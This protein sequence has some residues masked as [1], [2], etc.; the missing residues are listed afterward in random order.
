M[1]S[2]L[3]IM[4]KVIEIKDKEGK[5]DE[6]VMIYPT[7]NIT[8]KDLMK[9]GGKFYAILNTDTG[10]WITNESE[11]YDIIDKRLY[12]KL[13]EIGKEDGYGNIRDEKGRKIIVSTMDDSSTKNYLE[14]SNWFSKL[15]P[16][17]NLKP[18]DSNITFQG[19]DITPD[20]YVTKT[21]PYK[22]EKGSINAYEKL[23]NTLYSPDDRKKIEWAIGSVFNGDSK[24][25]EKF[26]VLYGDPGTGKSTVLDLIKDLFEGYYGI[27]VAAELA[28]KQSTFATSAFKDNPL[29]AIQDDGSL[30]KIDSPVINEI[31]SHKEV[32]INEKNK[33]QYPIRANAILFMATNELV[34]LH[35]TKLGITRRLLDVYPTGNKL[36]VREYRK[37]VSDLKYELGAIA[38]H[39]KSVYEE[40][41][42]EYY[43]DYEPREMIRKTNDLRNF[44][45]D[46]FDL[47]LD[48]KIVSRDL[49]YKWYKAYCEES[50]ITYILKRIDFGEQLREYYKNFYEIKWIDGKSQ[51]NIFEGFKKEKFEYASVKFEMKVEEE[52]PDWLKFKNTRSKFD[53]LYLDSPAQYA[54]EVGGIS[55]P[56]T[57][58]ALCTSTLKEIDTK[59]VHYVKPPENLICIDFDIKDEEGNKDGKKNLV[60]AGK[61]PETYGEYSKSGSGV[62]LYYIYNGDVSKLRSL[63]DKDIEIK[64]FRG[65]ASLR[66]KLTKCNDKEIAVISSGL[67]TKGEKVLDEYAV[68]N[69]KHLR[70]LIGKALRKEIEP[71]ATKTCMDYI[72][73]VTEDAYKSGLHFDVTDLRPD[74]Q[75]FANNSTH[76]ASY[77]LNLINKIHFA[78]DEA[79]DDKGRYDNDDIIIFDCEV[80]ENLFIVCWKVKGEGHEV[81]KMINPT[82]ADIEDLCHHKLVGYNNRA[83]DNH[84]LYARI[85]GYNN[86]QLY[87]L[88]QRLIGDQGRNAKFLEAYK[89][90]YSDVYDFLSAGNK[91]GL[92]KWEI[93]LGIHHQEMGIPWDKPVPKD[94]WELVADYCANDVI[95]T[96]KTWDANEADWLAREILADISGLTVNDTTNQCTTKLIVGNDKNPQDEFIYTDL[97]TIFPGYTF[98]KTGIDKKL[99]N[100]GTKIVAGKSLYLG[101]DPGEGGYVYAEPGIY[102]NV[103]LLDVASMHPHSA[104]RLKVFGE[105][106]TKVFEELV[107]ARVAIK[108]GDFEKAGKLLGG[109]LKPYLKDKKDAKK[110]ANALKTAINS[111]YGLTSATFNNKLRD[112]RNVDNI[113]A[114]Y[115]ALFMINLKHEV[116]KKGYTVV[117][118]KTDSIKIANMDDYIKDFCM[119]YANKYGFEFEHEATYE[120]ICLVNEAVY[121]AKDKSDGHWT[122]TGAQFQIPY[123]FKTL[124]SHEPVTFSDYCETKS[125]TTA[126]YLDFNENLKDVDEHNYEFVGKVGSFVP[127]V[128]GVGGGVLV[129]EKDGKYYAAT[130]T[131]KPNGK[132]VYRWLEAEQVKILGLEDKVDLSYFNNLANT[133]IETIDKFGD[134]NDFVSDTPSF[135]QIPDT[136]KDEIPFETIVSDD[137]M[138][139]PV[140]A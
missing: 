104:I 140:A 69:D 64:T 129:R 39:C 28:N 14:F 122:A 65:K 55:K 62:H 107:E 101:E 119:K 30:K 66:R 137:F 16:N 84:I 105:R 90:S 88:S 134:F 59:E 73:K 23:M 96:E 20:M 21:L 50:G 61:W 75:A 72:Y 29:V 133:A 114:K 34:D 100:E 3:K 47:F 81:V 24:K 98:S 91:M 7:Y 74:I 136:N 125:V 76:N 116:Q 43:I 2:F 78:S 8:G 68:K 82:P 49:A 83:Y 33:S 32:F 67:P 95:A 37:C 124:F 92:K 94:K 89:L 36:P 13:D 52:I 53:E 106:Y 138:N 111:I 131:K 35:D 15:P 99:Y 79:S 6:V 10:Y 135:M 109:K 97:S 22:M 120:K 45:S 25:N 87:E 5:K 31:I 93:K 42:K 86:Y 54:E 70:A 11:V 60:A 46:N 51:R 132:E 41:G 117:H 121:I 110:L 71:H 12:L 112:P 17:H 19:D 27:F 128:D 1:K 58:W 44:I 40:L 113:V 118:I 38:Y 123:V 18:L 115:G 57:T 63:Y 108:R 85:M 80:Y 126:L 26:V 139:K 48:N 102:T 9:K 130:G 103:G 127:V 77:C 4:T 56:V